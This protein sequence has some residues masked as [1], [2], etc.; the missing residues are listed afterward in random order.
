MKRLQETE[1]SPV[2]YNIAPRF[3]MTWM[4]E[5]LGQHETRVTHEQK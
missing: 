2:P 1:T 5:N 3:A 4:T